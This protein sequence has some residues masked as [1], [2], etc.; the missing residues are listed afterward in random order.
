MLRYRY[1]IYKYAGKAYESE[2][3]DE[4]FKEETLDDDKRQMLD[5]RLDDLRQGYESQ[6]FTLIGDVDDVAQ[7]MR[8]IDLVNRSPKQL[9]QDEL[10]GATFVVAFFEPITADS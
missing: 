1:A 4:Y 8:Q 6:G 9:A 5:E 10:D 7:T 2:A 3:Q